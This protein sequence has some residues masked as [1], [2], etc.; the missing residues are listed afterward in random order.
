MEPMF[1]WSAKRGRGLAD[2]ALENRGGLG[3][4]QIAAAAPSDE[5]GLAHSRRRRTMPLPHPRRCK[6]WIQ[7]GDWCGELG[8]PETQ[9]EPAKVKP[10]AT[11]SV[12]HPIAVNGGK[13]YLPRRG[14]V[15]SS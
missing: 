12:T 10:S 7:M 14:K 4:R 9:E 6:S 15:F 2:P 13:V 5:L 1:F 8:R 3:A 11:S